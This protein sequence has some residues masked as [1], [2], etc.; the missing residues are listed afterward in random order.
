MAVAGEPSIEKSKMEC[1]ENWEIHDVKDYKKFHLIIR[2]IYDLVSKKFHTIYLHE[3]YD[4]AKLNQFVHLFEDACYYCD[5]EQCKD[6]EEVIEKLEENKEG[7]PSWEK[8][9]ACFHP[10]A[11]KLNKK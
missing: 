9:W 7:L 4:I 2:T 3:S 11:N 8:V 5:A 10:M 6:C 1:D